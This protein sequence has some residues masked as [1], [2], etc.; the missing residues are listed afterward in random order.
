M[1]EYFN[2]N[3]KLILVAILQTGFCTLN[4]F[5]ESVPV[6]VGQNEEKLVIPCEEEILSEFDKLEGTGAE[7]GIYN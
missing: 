5:K 4:L 7:V 1:A 2:L 6:K 3:S